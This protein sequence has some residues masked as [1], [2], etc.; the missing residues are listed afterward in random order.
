VRR[1]LAH[2]AL[3]RALPIAMFVRCVARQIARPVTVGVRALIVEDGR[4]LLVRMHGQA[5]WELPGGGVKRGESLRTA[6]EREAREETGC[7][8]EAERLL[9]VYLSIHEGMTNHVA[10]FVCRPTTPPTGALN[11]E[12]AETR[13]WP[14]DGLPRDIASTL[15]QRLAEYQAGAVGLDGR[16]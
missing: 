14:I 8:V 4:V 9:G 7:V 10:V 2:A 3:H 11:I 6:A 13:W 16:W 1:R 12:I 15:S 5:R